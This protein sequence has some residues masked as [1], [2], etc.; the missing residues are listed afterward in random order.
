MAETA[1]A[2]APSAPGAIQDSWAERLVAWAKGHRQAVGYAA[3]AAIVIAIVVGWSILSSR[4]SELVA[5]DQLQ[6]AQVALEARNMPLAASEF[7]RIRENYAGTRAAEQ[8]TLLLAQVRLLQGQPQQAIDVLRDF[9]RAASAAY[10]GQA[11]GLLAAAYEN[12]GQN[13]E[14]GREYQAAA[15]AIGLPSLQAQY[16]SDAGR[17][18][19][20][21]GDTVQARAAY[22]KIVRDL[23]ETLPA[24]EATLRLGELTKGSAE[25]P[26]KN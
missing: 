1:H 7:A 20:A 22:E 21:A 13:A 11:H 6:Q 19:A 10:R 3:G 15:D 24:T 25:I 9:A 8:A 14:A 4:R 5:G 2:A 26:R 23:S 12:V 17:A 16:L 18:F